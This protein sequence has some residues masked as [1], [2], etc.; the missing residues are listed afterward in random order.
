MIA[1]STPDLVGGAVLALLC[2][3]WLVRDA[4]RAR[5]TRRRR[6]PVTPAR[7]ARLWV[8]DDGGDQ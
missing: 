8:V 1:T 2:G 4:L 7:H 5:R 6:R 3:G